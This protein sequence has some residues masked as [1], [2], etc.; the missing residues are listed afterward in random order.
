MSTA[1]I[2]GVQP[3]PPS[4]PPASLS[5]PP[6]PRGQFVPEERQVCGLGS[7]G[8][9]GR[10]NGNFPTTAPTKK[11]APGPPPR[12]NPTTL[13]C[14]LCS[15]SCLK[16]RLGP[17]KRRRAAGPD[18]SPCGRGRTF[19]AFVPALCSV[20]QKGRRG[21][22]GPFVTSLIL[23]SLH[24]PNS[25]TEIEPRISSLPSLRQNRAKGKKSFAEKQKRERG[26]HFC[27]GCV[28]GCFGDQFLHRISRRWEESRTVL[29]RRPPSTGGTLWR[30][31]RRQLR[32]NGCILVP[33]PC[34]LLFPTPHCALRVE[35]LPD[36][37]WPLQGW[38]PDT[39]LRADFHLHLLRGHHQPQRSPIQPHS[40]LPSSPSQG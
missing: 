19:R 10:S 6:S 36:R 15:R 1:E 5:V 38:G 11:E 22:Q 30:A 24:S 40:A 27:L 31:Q 14:P 13:P 8:G 33:S 12:A 25:L 23:I 17:S 9:T 29:P 39:S 26:A 28:S 35:T 34:L 32:R 20:L 18:L 7:L 37:G 16:E 3:L 2:C 4:R 21:W